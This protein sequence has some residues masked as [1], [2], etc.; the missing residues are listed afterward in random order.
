MPKSSHDLVKKIHNLFPLQI[1]DLVFEEY[2]PE[3]EY[4][5]STSTQAC[6]AHL[7]GA[8]Q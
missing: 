6:F 1:I 7:Q 3:E 8:P 2:N 4:V 5:L